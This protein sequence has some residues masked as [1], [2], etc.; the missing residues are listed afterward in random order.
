MQS[1]L[2]S[3]SAR[4]P[5]L[6]ESLAANLPTVRLSCH[7][8][9]CRVQRR[10]LVQTTPCTLWTVVGSHPRPHSSR[11]RS[12]QWSYQLSLSLLVLSQAFSFLQ[13]RV[14]Q[15]QPSIFHQIW[16]ILV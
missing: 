7:R 8:R 1:L 13:Q 12:S 14:S 4:S 11:I 5:Y 10:L 15:S 9:L 16:W 3:W 2:P 6:Y